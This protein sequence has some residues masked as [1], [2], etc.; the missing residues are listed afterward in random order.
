MIAGDIE[1]AGSLEITAPYD[2]SPIATIDTLDE[3][4]VDQALAKAHALFQNRDGWLT[5]AERII[6]LRRAGEIMQERA[7]QLALEAARE[8]GKPLLDSRVE[9]ARAIDGMQICIETLRTEGGEEIPMGVNAASLGHLAF[10]RREPI[11][12][13]VALSAFNHPLNLIVHQVGP[14]VATG[15]PVIV[16]PAADTPLSCMHFIEILLEAGLP[17]GWVQGMVTSDHKVATKLVTDPRVDFFSFIGSAKVGW[18][19]RSQLYPGT[20]CA[21]E[22]GGAA[23]VI[24]AADAD[25]DDAIPLLAKGGFYHAGQ[26][27]VSVQRVFAHQSISRQLAEGLAQQGAAMVVGD[28]V[29]EATAIG[30]LIRPREVERIHEW[31]TEAV[32]GGAELLCG[33]EP[34]SE[35]C[36]PASV[37][38]NPPADAKVSTLEVFAPV[39]CVYSYDDLD[40]ALERANSLPYAFQSAIFTKSLETSLRAYRR[41][42]ASAVMVNQFTAFRVDWMPFAGLRQSG[43]G[44]GGIPHSMRDMQVEKMM[45]IRSTEI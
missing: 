43:M 32:Q 10:T 44:V 14:A 23:P 25:L 3:R 21:L 37:L 34:I 16:K 42:N 8:G 1:P 2:Q 12:V 31:V 33:G 18:W 20:R 29:Q 40:E 38:L 15:C 26:V 19:L 30:P 17:E 36:Y 9:V 39:I 22:H 7:E 11:G 13:V 28:P 41:L 6:I 4:G 27:C 5:A 24:V 45:V 35:T